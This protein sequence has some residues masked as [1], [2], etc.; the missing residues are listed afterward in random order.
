[1]FLYQKE[2]DPRIYLKIEL[3]ELT[4]IQKRSFLENWF[5]TGTDNLNARV[6]DAQKLGLYP[7]ITG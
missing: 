1:M 3:Y 6:Q 2:S 4:V 7:K 5:L